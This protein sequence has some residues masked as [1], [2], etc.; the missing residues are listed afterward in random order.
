M[1][2]ATKNGQGNY[3]IYQD[4][5]HVSTGSSAILGNYGLS[6]SNLTSGTSAASSPTSTVTPSNA[7]PAAPTQPPNT[8]LQPGQ[9]GNDV[10]ALQLW[11]IQNGYGIPD[12]ATGFYGAQTKAA[13]N[14]L[15]T[16]LG[17]DAGADGGF[18]GPK[19]YGAITS[20]KSSFTQ[21]HGEDVKNT[22]SDDETAFF[23]SDEYK[24]LPKDQQD[25]IRAVF[26]TVQTNDTQKKDLL[27]KAIAKA[28]ENAD[29]IFK[30]TLRLSLDALNSGFQDNASDLDYQE[31]QLTDR[32]TQLREDTAYSTN[33]LSIEHQNE[34]KQYEDDLAQ[35]LGDTRQ[36]LAASGFTDSSKRAK[37]EEILQNAKGNLVESSNRTFAA[38]TRDLSSTLSRTEAD[39]AAEIERLRTVAGSKNKEL[40]RETEKVVGSG[41]LRTIPGYDPLGNIIGKS[42]Q[43]RQ[44]DIDAAAADYY[45]LGFV[46]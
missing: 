26:D 17:V 38:K 43:D 35:K 30:Q 34:L 5:V 22:Q 4:G 25:A 40:G 36:S 16:K 46:S 20:G 21:T 12:G 33:D 45:Q 11:L 6:P 9:S 8:N 10:K 29:P 32:L 27:Q 39:T 18:Y 19:T 13:V 1:Y 23:N 14:A 44:K 28:T 31:K 24:N 37:S 15:Q 2:T 3:D 41:N 7:Q 42:E